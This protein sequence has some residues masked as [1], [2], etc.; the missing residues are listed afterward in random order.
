MGA[1]D[2]LAGH[3]V[4]EGS[5]RYKCSAYLKDYC[6]LAL[7]HFRLMLLQ[8][9]FKILSSVTFYSFWRTG[10]PLYKLDVSWPKS[11]EKLTGQTFCVAVDHIHGLVYVGQVRK[12]PYT[13]VL[14]RDF[15]FIAL[16]VVNQQPVGQVSCRLLEKV[17]YSTLENPHFSVMFWI[18]S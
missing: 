9:I 8:F 12:G 4:G 7:V 18:S 2:P 11:P 16:M 17:C 5:M 3:V 10:K 14:S 13:C 15:S 1:P 6:F